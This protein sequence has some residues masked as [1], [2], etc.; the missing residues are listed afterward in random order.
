MRNRRLRAPLLSALLLLFAGS[1]LLAQA[2]TG[3]A[4]MQGEVLDANGKPVEGAKIT[5]HLGDAG[6][7]PISTNAKGKWSILGLA[8][9]VWKVLIEKPGYVTSEG[10]LKVSEFQPMQP[11][12]IRLRE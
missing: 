3:R 12:S 8:D 11:L 6:P 4:R 9:G 10:S 5:L 1:A 2:W 7:A